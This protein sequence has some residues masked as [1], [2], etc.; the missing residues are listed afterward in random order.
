MV[1]IARKFLGSHERHPSV[2]MNDNSHMS[3]FVRDRECCA[4]PVVLNDGTALAAAHSAQLGQAKGV[5]VL[6]R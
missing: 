2:D 4:K 1:R 6:L 5:T 3:Q